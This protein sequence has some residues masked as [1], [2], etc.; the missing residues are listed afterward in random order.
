MRSRR[1]NAQLGAQ[2]AEGAGGDGGEG[3]PLAVEDGDLHEEEQEP[4]EG[5][6]RAP[7]PERENVQPAPGFGVDWTGD[8]G[9]AAG[10]WKRVSRDQSS[11]SKSR[12]GW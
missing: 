9:E 11:T 7:A 5:M 3:E 2:G 1:R 4:G 8:G 10:Q 12:I 6:Q